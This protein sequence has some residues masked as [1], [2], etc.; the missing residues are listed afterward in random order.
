MSPLNLSD[1]GSFVA[2]IT[3][4]IIIIIITNLKIE[5]LL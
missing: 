2:I 4:N 3:I 1:L 5:S